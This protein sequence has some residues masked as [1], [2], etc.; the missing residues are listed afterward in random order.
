MGR[1]SI[2]QQCEASFYGME[3]SELHKLNLLS[4]SS[5]HMLVRCLD[6]YELKELTLEA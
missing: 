6:S 4:E 1:P 5:I 2:L 3:Q